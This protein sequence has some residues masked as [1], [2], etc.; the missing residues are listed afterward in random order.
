MFRQVVAAH[1]PFIALAAREPL[2]ARVRFD[3]PLQFVGAHESLAAE[4]PVAQKRPLA[5]VPAQVRLEVRRLGVD[6]AAAGNVAG[7]L[8]GRR[9][10]G[11]QLRLRRRFSDGSAATVGAVAAG[12]IRVVGVLLVAQWRTFFGGGT[13]DGLL[14][15]CEG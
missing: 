3:V 12:A 4:Q 8:S 15:C 11:R 14:D 13:R 10:R 5:A 2:L 9:R 1:E 6:L 7:V